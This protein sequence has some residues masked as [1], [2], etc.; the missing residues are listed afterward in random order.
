MSNKKLASFVTH[1]SFIILFIMNN[2]LEKILDIP[3]N[4]EASW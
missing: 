1:L 3:L 4:T 2:I